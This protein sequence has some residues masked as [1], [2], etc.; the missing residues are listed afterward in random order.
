MAAAR[1]RSERRDGHPVKDRN[2]GLILLPFIVPLPIATSHSCLPNISTEYL[3]F[4][5]VSLEFR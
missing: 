4:L 1:N 2:P 3:Y 5:A